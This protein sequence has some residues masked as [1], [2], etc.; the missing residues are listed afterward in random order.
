MPQRMLEAG[1][2]ILRSVSS[3]PAGRCALLSRPLQRAAWASKR[4]A[5]YMEGH[6]ACTGTTQYYTL[7]PGNVIQYQSDYRAR[8]TGREAPSHVAEQQPKHASKG[9]MQAPSNKRM[10]TVSEAK[11]SQRHRSP[12][13]NRKL[14]HAVKINLETRKAVASKQVAMQH[15]R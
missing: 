8:K 7:H 1:P 3:A 11:L 2:A 10:E 5:N 13:G 4:M 6:T 9:R 15:V 14:V 12:A